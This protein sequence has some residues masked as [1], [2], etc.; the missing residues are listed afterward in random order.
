MRT[1]VECGCLLSKIVYNRNFVLIISPLGVAILLTYAMALSI[2]LK[3]YLEEMEA[4]IIDSNNKIV[5]DLSEKIDKVD[6]KY[7]KL[8]SENEQLKSVVSSLIGEV[9]FLSTKERMNNIFFFGVEEVTNSGDSTLKEVQ[10]LLG[11]M[12]VNIEKGSMIDARRLG[13]QSGSKSRPI[14][15]KLEDA[16]LKKVIFEK[17]AQFYESKKIRLANDLLALERADREELWK[18][19]KAL[20]SKGIT[21]KVKGTKLL[22]N[23]RLFSSVE[24]AK[25]LFQDEKSEYECDRSTRSN[26][27]SIMSTSSQQRK[28]VRKSALQSQKNTRYKLSQEDLNKIRLRSMS[29]N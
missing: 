29:K 15:L 13:R 27:A 25:L 24:A 9:S 22:I 5:K 1:V 12:T 23:N 18:I 28:R 21:S 16:S 20:Y 26:S 14:L 4:R 10:L 11:D 2:E 3:K 8:L 17:I 19:R 7:V 6:L